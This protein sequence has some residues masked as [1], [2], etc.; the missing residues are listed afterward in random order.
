MICSELKIANEVVH[1][2]SIAKIPKIFSNHLASVSTTSIGRTFFVSFPNL[3]GSVYKKIKIHIN[4]YTIGKSTANFQRRTKEN[5][6]KKELHT[7]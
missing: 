5:L 3:Y 1:S 6:I 4:L 7:K 2:F